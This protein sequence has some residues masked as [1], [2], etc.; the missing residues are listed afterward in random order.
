MAKGYRRTEGEG[1]MQAMDVKWL[2]A[3]LPED[4]VNRVAKLGELMYYSEELAVDTLGGLVALLSGRQPAD[5]LRAIARVMGDAP[6]GLYWE[7]ASALLRTLEALERVLDLAEVRD[8]L[9]EPDAALKWEPAPGSAVDAYGLAKDAV[10]AMKE[11]VHDDYWA[12]S[13]VARNIKLGRMVMEAMLH[14]PQMH[15]SDRS[16]VAASMGACFVA[17]TYADKTRQPV[18]TASL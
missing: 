5:L 11:R 12:W 13:A 1:T 6:C 15:A 2:S 7:D 18:G 9:C 8:A 14:D 4:D 16:R 17:K 10:R 3:W